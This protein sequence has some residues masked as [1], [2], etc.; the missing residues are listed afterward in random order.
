MISIE[1]SIG[2][3][4]S[5]LLRLLKDSVTEVDGREIVYISEPVDVWENIKDDN[6]RSILELFYDD[7]KKMAFSFQ[8]CAYISRQ[9]Q[10][11]KAFRESPGAIFVCERSIHTDKAIF[12]RMNY[13]CGNISEVDYQ[14]YLKW[15]DEFNLDLVPVRSALV[16]VDSDPDVCFTR[17]R[18][19]ARKGEEGVSLEYLQACG[20]AHEDWIT[21][22]SLPVM[23]VAADETKKMETVERVVEFIRKV[24]K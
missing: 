17:T 5:T 4:K 10:L 11:R 12:A 22:S 8:M 19:R 14:I 9:A 16:Y 23:R 20:K 24:Y 6:G 2:G 7:P 1:G 3:G 18:E 13:E 21:G 15:F